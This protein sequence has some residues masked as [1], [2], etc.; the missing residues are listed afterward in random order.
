MRTWTR[1]LIERRI[2]LGYLIG[3][4]IGCDDAHYARRLSISWTFQKIAKGSAMWQMYARTR[5]TC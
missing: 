1:T 3:L 4:N 5:N 2:I